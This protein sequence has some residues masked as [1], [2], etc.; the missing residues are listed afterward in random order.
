MD[1]YKVLNR[2]EREREASAS[3]IPVPAYLKPNAGSSSSG[4][5]VFVVML[6]KKK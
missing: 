1:G 3:G 5:N 2:R 6:W 4:D